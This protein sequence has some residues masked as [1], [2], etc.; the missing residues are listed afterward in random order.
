M[1]RSFT[2]F[3]TRKKTPVYSY[4]VTEGKQWKAQS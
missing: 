1:Q 4:K 2:A 3:E